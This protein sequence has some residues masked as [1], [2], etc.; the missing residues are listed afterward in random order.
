MVN[1]RKEFVLS[2]QL[3]RSGTSIGANVSEA[4]RGQSKNDFVYKLQISR[5]EAN[6]TL[7]WLNL[8]KATSFIQLENSERLTK[9]CDE[10][11]R[12]LTAI[13]KTSE[14]KSH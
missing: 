6:E 14:I 4:V 10:L 9:Q 8:L 11:L 12:I 2:K 3:L 7:Y 13:I 1:E 5:K